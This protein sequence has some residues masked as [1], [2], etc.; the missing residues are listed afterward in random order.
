M[1]VLDARDPLSCRCK[2]IERKILLNLKNQEKEFLFKQLSLDLEKVKILVEQ[3]TEGR[4]L[5]LF[6]DPKVNVLSLNIALDNLN[7]K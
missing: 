5:G 7:G 6:G 4:Q 3:F 2:Y 1:E